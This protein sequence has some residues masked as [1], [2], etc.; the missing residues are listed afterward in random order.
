MDATTQIRN[1][2]HSQSFP[3][4]SVPWTTTLTSRVPTPPLPS[5][6]ATAKA[7]LLASD[8]TTPNLL[9]PSSSATF[10]P[11]ATDPQTPETTLPRDVPCQVLDVENLALSRWEQVE[12]LEAVARGE[13]T[14]GR[15][16]VRL[17]AAEE[18]AEYDNVDEGAAPGRTQGGGGGGGG[19][20]RRSR[21][22]MQR[23]GLCCR[24]A[25]GR[26]CMRWS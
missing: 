20:R 13:M 9:D 25:R 1:A 3:T 17:A 21:G 22:R 12:E 19:Q 18:Q 23:I 8:L 11:A 15:R 16:V 4:P 24:I 7:R 10:P 14:T 5:L 2:L 6:I 26:R